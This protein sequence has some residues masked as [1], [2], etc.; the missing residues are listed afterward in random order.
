MP[1]AA[2]ARVPLGSPETSVDVEATSSEAAAVLFFFFFMLMSK[3]S[4]E[5]VSSETEVCSS[6]IVTFLLCSQP[7]K[8]KNKN[9]DV[10]IY[11]LRKRLLVLE[12]GH[13]IVLCRING[14][15][16][17]KILGFFLIFFSYN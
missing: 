1:D 4:M 7:L 5:G 15:H 11:V 16:N 9:E 8:C 6:L 3:V 2:A 10:V 12:T 14:T 13:C 17:L